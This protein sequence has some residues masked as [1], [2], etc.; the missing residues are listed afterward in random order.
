M[1][2]D[3]KPIAS[4]ILRTKNEET[5]ISHCLNAIFSQKGVSF[6]VILV[7]NNSTDSTLSQ[8]EKFDVKVMTIHEF[9]PGRALNIGIEE[10]RGEFVIC[11]SGHC[12]PTNDYWL[13]NLLEDF[14]DPQV[15][16]IYGRQL[17]LSYSSD[18]DKRDLLTT[19]GL[20]KKIQRKDPF[21]H[22]AN[23]AIRKSIWEKVP[24]DDNVTNVED[25]IWGKKVIELGMILIYEPDASVYHWHGINHDA[26]PIRAKKV[27]GVLEKAGV[28]NYE[29]FEPVFKQDFNPIFVIPARKKDVSQIGKSS[30]TSIVEEIKTR[31]VS[32]TIALVSDDLA[33]ISEARDLH[34]EHLIER[35]I[36]STFDFVD[37]FEL[38]EKTYTELKSLGEN[39]THMILLNGNYPFRNWK[40]LVSSINEFQPENYDSLV[41]VTP[42]M[43]SL[44]S[45]DSNDDGSGIYSWTK[46]MP[47]SL[48]SS[49]KYMSIFG[50]GS[51][52]SSDF[53]R[54]VIS[55]EKRI[56]LHIVESKVEAL[57]IKTEI[58]LALFK[59][60][61]EK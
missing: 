45:D 2:K 27:M 4:I 55:D 52:L 42:M 38:L 37:V 46:E 47:A 22:N 40:S 17:P 49:R 13:K 1:E 39:F 20:D 51:I 7:D 36:Y 29:K 31:F 14:A 30:F 53:I 43:H 19:F 10:A 21:F 60:R 41:S 25:R 24:F 58:D 57:E 9:L 33:L 59:A 15:A 26:N 50:Y 23:S 44:W 11:L 12:V 61:F 34:V 54:E 28:Y 48:N 16:G 32:P 56:K 3:K 18:I 8:V 5:W 35:D 6:E